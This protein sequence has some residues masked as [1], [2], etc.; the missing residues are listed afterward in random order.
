MRP[1]PP[2]CVAAAI[3][4]ALAIVAP[5][6]EL[7]AHEN[8]ATVRGRLAYSCFPADSD[9]AEGSEVFILGYSFF[10]V[11]GR[12]G[13]FRMLGVP[14]RSSGYIVRAS[15]STGEDS[16]SEK[17]RTGAVAAGQ[18]I[19]VGTIEMCP[20]GDG[21]RQGDEVC[22]GE[23]LGDATCADEGFSGGVLACSDS[24]AFDTSGCIQCPSGEAFCEETGGC[25][26]KIETACSDAID[27]D[28]DGKVDLEDSNCVP[29]S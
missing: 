9:I 7:R 16:L 20:C 15:R 12:D 28:C 22:D 21:A 2:S 25:K 29:P 24:C 23:E 17:A 14:P 8:T 19:D 18:T 27:N 3:A 1:L 10:V 5:P 11:T 6:A 13:S 4:V 26:P